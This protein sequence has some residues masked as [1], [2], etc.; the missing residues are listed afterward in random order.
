MYDINNRRIK[1]YHNKGNK[2]G[3]VETLIESTSNVYLNRAIELLKE[4]TL[5]GSEEECLRIIQ[6]IFKAEDRR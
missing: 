1:T 6:R 2:E 4:E 5:K 3:L